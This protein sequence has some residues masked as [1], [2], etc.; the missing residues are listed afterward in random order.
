MNFTYYNIRDKKLQ[1]FPDTYNLAVPFE[2]G[3][4]KSDNRALIILDHVP[5]VDLYEKKLL[6][7][8]SPFTFTCEDIINEAKRISKS[9]GYNIDWKF[10]FY[11]FNYFGWYKLDST[12][13]NFAKH[14]AEVR[15]KDYIEKIKPTLIIV[16]GDE[17][18]ERLLGFNVRH[19]RGCLHKYN[20]IPLVNTLS[21]YH[22][23]SSSSAVVEVK[24]I[25]TVGYII[26][27]ISTGLM[28]KNPLSVSKVKPHPIVI[29]TIKKFDRMM[30]FLTKA[31]V[32]SIDT[33]TESLDVYNN[34]LLV[35][36]F[37]I[38]SKSAFVLPVYHKD[39]SWT[40]KDIQYIEKVMRKFFS[41]KV[42]QYSGK[43]TKY[44]VGQNF[45]FDIRIIMKW[46][47][48]SY[49]YYPVWDLMSGE[50]L[51]DENMIALLSSG[52][53]P[54]ELRQI[55]AH[56][57]NTFFYTSKF[58]KEDRVYIKDR[59]L[60]D[61]IDYCAMDVQ[62]PYAIHKKQIKRFEVHKVENY[63][64]LML[65]HQ[66]LIIKMTS[67]ME[68]RGS[69]LDVD[70]ILN[71]LKPNNEFVDNLE[72]I[73]KEFYSLRE[74]KL[75]ANL[76]K[77]RDSIPQ[78]SLF[79]ED[80]AHFS[81][82]DKSHKK[83]LFM[84]VLKLK[85]LK[86]SRKTNQPS[87][88]IHFLEEYEDKH[89][90]IQLLVRLSKLTTLKSTFIDAFY[91]HISNSNDGR[92]DGRIRPS[93]GATSTVTGR[94]NSFNPSLQQIP[95]H[96]DDAKIV[97]RMLIVPPLHIHFE[98]DYSAHEVRCWGIIS[99]D[100]VIASVFKSANK[101]IYNYR[102]YPTAENKSKLDNEGDVHKQ[103]YSF[104]T[105]VKPKN[106]TPDM[107][108][109]SKG[110]TFGSIYGMSAS[111]LAT[112]INKN[113][114]ETE[115]IMRKFFSRFEK[116]GKWLTTTKKYARKHFYIKSPIDRRR[117][118]PGYVFHVNKVH[119]ALD[120][121]SMN[122]PIQGFASDI[123]LISADIYTRA[124]NKCIRKLPEYKFELPLGPNAFVH[125][126]LKSEAPFDLL[127]LNLHLIEWSMT[128]GV[129]QYLKRFYDYDIN[130]PLSIEIEIGSDWSNKKKWDWTK[131]NLDDLIIKSINDHKILY[132][133][134]KKVQ[135][136][137]AKKTL[138]RMKMKYREQKKL[139]KLD[140]LY[141]INIS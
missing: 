56:Y 134:N 83:I 75:A 9:Y 18:A 140:K 11:N 42:K 139:L 29:D 19:L 118:L 120:R 73:K 89:K 46:L 43:D 82:S 135:K 91:K 100:N 64:R 60:K 57:G 25:N 36:Q 35:I 65:L 80:K 17:V 45:G 38:S 59:D 8:K 132:P 98:A 85:P 115:D 24:N 28:L 99:N 133:N 119:A 67:L 122:S 58:R 112:K 129:K 110:I 2:R 130:I 106:V 32:I 131:K 49:M 23:S 70:Y 72:K 95:E 53:K 121:L 108:Q 20:N 107:R 13:Q 61:V 51:F 117:N 44:F 86:V 54:F 81:L 52:I 33:E 68:Y 37:A 103:T 34:K 1:N 136:L 71:L 102:N 16:L 55:A 141:P 40:R 93:F 39:C 92:K 76:I 22:P 15:M 63:H 114:L 137:D 74:I 125:D 90:S 26:R 31:K 128:L 62:L 88:D 96:V 105:G 127:L 123:C 138:K 41:R 12:K 27:N 78:Q 5:T 69:Q 101:H 48:I 124:L 6:S 109:Q 7:P 30:S 97:K 87:F 21:L 3:W 77:K 4:N 79:A 111:S 10:T 50:Y 94:S 14:Q 66:S 113:A 116:A 84:D 126:S 104:F 47:N